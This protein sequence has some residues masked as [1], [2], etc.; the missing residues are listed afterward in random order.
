MAEGYQ[1]SGDKVALSPASQP[2]YLCLQPV[3]DPEPVGPVERVL[4]SDM[5][6]EC[7]CNM[8]CP[9]SILPWCTPCDLSNSSH[10]NIRGMA[11]QP[12][13][14]HNLGQPWSIL[15]YRR[16]RHPATRPLGTQ[17][18]DLVPSSPRPML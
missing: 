14:K 9:C 7:S 3:P 8:A 16:R 6:R 11:R 10:V 5:K 15:F 13:S 18:W 12:L 4:F 2:L 1:L 17:G